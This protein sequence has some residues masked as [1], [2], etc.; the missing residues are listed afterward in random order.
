MRIIA[1]RFRGR[2][3]AG[4]EGPGVR[5]TSDRLRETL[6]NV[7]A[8]RIGGARVLDAF[9]GTGAL[10]LEAAS[11]GAL[12]VTLVESDRHALAV[13]E[14]NVAHCGADAF[15]DVVR[16]RFPRVPAGGATFDL[17]LL[18][19]P[20]DTPDLEEILAAAS[21]RLAP[22]GLVVLEHSGRRAA[23]EAAGSVVRT[24]LLTAGD[25]ALSFYTAAAGGPVAGS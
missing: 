7:L 5:P 10:G 16:G 20:Y 22:G 24:R 13:I 19:P 11:R 12:S 14:K 17:I 4:P 1:G 25:S 15:C 23:P 2:K 21:G 18:D 3:L 6:F 9:A 8:R